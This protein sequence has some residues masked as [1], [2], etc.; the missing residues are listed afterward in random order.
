MF[1][2]GVMGPL[3]RLKC[4]LQIQLDKSGES[5]VGGNKHYNGPVDVLR[6]LYREGGVRS[7]FRGTGVTFF[8]DVPS[9][10][11]YFGTYEFLK[12][13]LGSKEDNR[14][15]YLMCNS[16]IFVYPCEYILCVMV[17]ANLLTCQKFN[18]FILSGIRDQCHNHYSRPQVTMTESN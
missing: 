18:I 8:R 15:A 11:F 7:I 16:Y 17:E 13:A 9:N 4:L 5:L 2:A 12:N 10:A 3:E 14:F 6:Q 1:T